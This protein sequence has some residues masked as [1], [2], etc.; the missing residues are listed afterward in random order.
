[1]NLILD[2]SVIAKLFLEE[3]GSEEALEIME[4]SYIEDLKIIASDLI[5][6]EVGNTIW[7]HLRNKKIDGI[8]YIKKLFLLNIDYIPLSE[9]LACEAMKL[10][11]KHGITYY[12][13]VHMALSQE[14]K[15]PLVTEDKLLLNK[16]KT[17]INLTKAIEEI[18]KI[19]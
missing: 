12:D 15:S 14:Y 19:G 18:K 9:N 13:G 10:A 6:Y 5:F 1:M 11:H 3:T 16:F 17:A 8:E 7:K 2:S 4:S